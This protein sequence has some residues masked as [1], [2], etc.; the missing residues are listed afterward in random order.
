VFFK[1]VTLCLGANGFSAALQSECGALTAVY[2]YWFFTA[3]LLT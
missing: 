3:G 1:P 2:H